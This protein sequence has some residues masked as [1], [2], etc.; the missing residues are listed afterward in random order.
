MT[1]NSELPDY[2]N[3]FV[4]LYPEQFNYG[5]GY[6]YAYRD[7][8]EGFQIYRVVGVEYDTQSCK[9]II[10]MEVVKAPKYK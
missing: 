1:Y 6:G 2:Y 7:C 5:Y 9:K 4:Q 10:K 3:A 8:Y